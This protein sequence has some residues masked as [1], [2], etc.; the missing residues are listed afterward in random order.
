MEKLY[1]TFGSSPKF[2]YGRDDYLVI[3]GTSKKDCTDT[4]TKYYPKRP[5]S[6]CINCSDYYTQEKWNEEQPSLY[7]NEPVKIIV[8]DSLYD[9]RVEGFE[10]LWLAVPEK[11]TIIFLQEGSGYNLDP[12]DKSLEGYVDYFDY[13]SFDLGH[14]EV[15]E[16]DG[17]LFLRK[18]LIREQYM[19]LTD[20]IPDILNNL[21]GDPFLSAHVIGEA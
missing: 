19:C 16:R 12:E 17:G 9:R 15:S 10:P 8:S 1:F 6:D 7:G 20:A 18:K 3:Y 21:F 5:G 2:P 13:T 14:G 11:G 4:F